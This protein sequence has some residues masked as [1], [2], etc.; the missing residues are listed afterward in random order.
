MPHLRPLSPAARAFA[1]SRCRVYLRPGARMPHRPTGMLFVPSLFS[2][3]NQIPAN[4]SS[5]ATTTQTLFI[6]APCT[7]TAKLWGAGGGGFDP[8]NPSVARGG[9]GGFATAVFSLQT[10]D[11]VT[12]AA[13]GRGLSDGSGGGSSGSG[14]RN[15][16]N[17]SCSGGGATELY[18]NGVPVLIAG[19][20]GGAA[21]TNGGGGGGTNGGNGSDFDASEPGGRGASSIAPGAGGTAAGSTGGNGSPGSGGAG[22][23]G[24]RNDPRVPFGGGGGGGL[25]GGGG[26]A[27]AFGSQPTG[28]GG[29]SGYDS[30]GT[31]TL[32]AATNWQAANNS[33]PDWIGNA[34]NAE[35]SG[36]VVLKFA[37]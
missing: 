31:G 34:G 29:G 21:S 28:A 37:A 24:G 9:G 12:Y 8:F 18:I 7:M 35:V 6:S 30:T 26:G 16:G 22:G 27:S 2:I 20:G 5:Q 3:V 23:N 13:G 11:V 32:T 15:G 17:G 10:G 14:T 19:G 33:D 1:R 25:F 36:L 4:I